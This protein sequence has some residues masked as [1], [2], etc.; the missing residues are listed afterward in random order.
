[1]SSPFKLP[2][3]SQP[4]IEKSNE[5]DAYASLARL[6]IDPVMPG[7][8][9]VLSNSSNRKI[10]NE[11]STNDFGKCFSKISSTKDNERDEIDVVGD[12]LRISR[13]KGPPCEWG[14]KTKG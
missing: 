9:L 8:R 10:I 12:V 6:P 5:R 4:T 7:E 14:L 1:M 13:Q 3:V 2:I 11:L